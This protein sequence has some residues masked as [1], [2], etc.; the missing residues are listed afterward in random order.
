M[1]DGPGAAAQHLSRR[2]RVVVIGSE[3]TGKTTLAERLAAHYGV[4]LAPEFVR[5]YAKAKHSP[6]ESGDVEPIAR[7]QLVVEDETAASAARLGSGLVILDTDLNSTVV[8]ARHYYDACPM[9]IDEAAR[10][11]PADLYL[12]LDIDVP[13]VADPQRDR[14]SRRPEMHRL[15]QERLAEIGAHHV[16]ISGSWDERFARATAAID[17]LL[18]QRDAGTLRQRRPD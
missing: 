18:R 7:G 3:S 15:F 1:A 6:L 16:V 12:I 5:R 14:G 4:P 8:Y 13:W 10:V 17:D 9:W 2:I 11:R